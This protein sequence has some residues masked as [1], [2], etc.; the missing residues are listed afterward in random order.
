MAEWLGLPGAAERREYG[1][2][3]GEDPSGAPCWFERAELV[4]RK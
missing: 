3:D 4:G 2:M 1:L